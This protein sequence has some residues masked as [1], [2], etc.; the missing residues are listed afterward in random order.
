ME[1][2]KVEFRKTENRV[3][4]AA[5]RA[6]DELGSKCEHA[7]EKHGSAAFLALWLQVVLLV[8][9]LGRGC[10]SQKPGSQYG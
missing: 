6:G 7:T 3:F 2:F 1:E 10:D 4:R 8:F 5:A 9:E